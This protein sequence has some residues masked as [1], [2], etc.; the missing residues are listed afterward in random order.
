MEPAPFLSITLFGSSLLRCD[1]RPLA[2]NLKGTTLELL[3]FLVANAG[4]QIR[5]EY[6]ADLF[7]PN[8]SCERQRSALNS[9]IWR[10]GKKLPPYPGLRLAAT[11]T[12]FSM[13]IDDSIPVDTR[14]LYTLVRQ[15]CMPQGLT[16]AGALKL[17]AALAACGAPF[18]DGFDADWT[19]AE[20][21]KISNIRIRG[22][23]TLMHWHAG[24]RNYEDAL[25]IGR[26]VLHEDPF[27]EAVQIDMMW[28]YVLNGQR[29][30]AIR[31]YQ[32]FAAM[33]KKEMAIEPM[34]ETR[35][36]YE[37]IRDEL[38]FRPDRSAKLQAKSALSSEKVHDMLALGLATAE[39]SRREFYDTLRA[40][41]G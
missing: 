35:A 13:T 11:D 1:G 7:W 6:A 30:Q 3:W 33:L 41:L 12:T 39:Q 36:L 14:D 37:H 34:L 9:A 40:Q 21:E 31:Q 23:I 17:E 26:A 27:R 22:M 5:R 16:E 20:R 32:S 2:L 29:V 15:A 25:Q 10:I 8:S 24:K 18:M 19:L 28:L 38:D 4:H